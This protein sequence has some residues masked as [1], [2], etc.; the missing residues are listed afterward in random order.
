[1]REGDA[2][3]DTVAG[4]L[5]MLHALQA[6]DLPRFLSRYKAT[7]EREYDRQLRRIQALA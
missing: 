4:F 6:G 1:M 5:R 2:R 7:T 3:S